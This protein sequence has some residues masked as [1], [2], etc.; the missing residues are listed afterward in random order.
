[1]ISVPHGVVAG[2]VTGAYR[3]ATGSKQIDQSLAIWLVVDPSREPL[4]K[5]WL[6]RVGRALGQEAMYVERAGGT[7]DFI[8]TSKA[9]EKRHGQQ[10]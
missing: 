10:G 3:M 9:R 4:L 8:R 6:A 1:M 2:T 5:R 7:V